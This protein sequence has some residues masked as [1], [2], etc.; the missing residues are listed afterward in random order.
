MPPSD[1][2]IGHVGLVVQN[3]KRMREFYINV[4]G[5]QQTRDAMM[6]GGPIDELTGLHQVKLEAVFIGTP[7]RP[8]AIELLQ[9]HNH[10]DPTPS[11]GPSGNGPNHVQIVVNDL[12]QV[13]EAL[14]NH[15]HGVWGGPVNWPKRWRRVLYAKDPEG[16]V[17]EFNERIPGTKYPGV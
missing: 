7:D 6:E 17:V 5:L 11:R 15:G 8:E 12:D 4:I 16:N 2:A 9:Y 3:M 1:P 13:V 10:P 14:R